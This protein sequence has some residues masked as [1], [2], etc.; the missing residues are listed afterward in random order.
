MTGWN[1]KN[2]SNHLLL[3]SS[4][5]GLVIVFF[6]YFIDFGVYAHFG[7]MPTQPQLNGRGQEQIAF[8]IYKAVLEVSIMY[9][10]HRGRSLSVAS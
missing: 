1:I 4:S 7:V 3:L 8:R 10:R 5:K 6:F 2:Y 9:S